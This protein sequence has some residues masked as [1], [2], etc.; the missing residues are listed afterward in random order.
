MAER[1]KCPH[2]HK[3]NYSADTSNPKWKCCHC[4]KT[5]HKEESESKACE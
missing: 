3:N 4:N 5:F 2:C 1:R